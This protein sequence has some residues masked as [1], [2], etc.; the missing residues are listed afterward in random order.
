LRQP[1][2]S[3]E[4]LDAFLDEF[5]DAVQK[6]FPAC[7][8]RFEGWAEVDAVR[9]LERYRHRVCCYNGDIQGTAGVAVAGLLSALRITGGRL[10]D[11]RILFLGAGSAAIGMAD[12]IASA[13]TLEGPTLRQAR[14]RISLFDI[15]GLLEPSRTD[16]YGLQKL[17]AHPHAPTRDF[18]GAIESL[19]PTAIVGGI[20]KGKSF[21]REIIEAMARLN[22]RP[23]IFALS[24]PTD[25]AE[26]T[27]EE[28]YR[29]SEG[30][31]LYAAG[32]QFPEIRIGERVLVPSQANS[33]YIVPAVGLAIYAT[34]AKRVPNE[35]FVEAAR[36]VAEQVTQAELDAGL[37]Y[38][39]QFRIL[40]TEVKAAERAA[41]IV[42]A[43]GLAGVGRP[44]N[45]R[46]FIQSRL[47]RPETPLAPIG[48]TDR[49][50][51]PGARPAPSGV[52]L[53]AGEVP[54]SATS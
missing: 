41:D 16:L 31:A 39:P 25:H 45:L 21:T 3:T 15:N 1:R 4:E 44:D 50:K 14:Q 35:I 11:Q 2:I 17:Y 38:P 7:C 52:N 10:T 51:R 22:R 20:N 40:E 53:R 29:W 30:R 6:V 26:C 37:L 27:A 23:I 28:A 8:I 24:N 18:L 5:V 47:Y 36:A 32:V 34:K 49:A 48:S 46:T 43:H 54:C 9:L 19:K 42:F 33:M 12:L 13:I